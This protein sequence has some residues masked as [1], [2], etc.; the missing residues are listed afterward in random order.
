MTSLSVSNNITDF[1]Q[2]EIDDAD[3]VGQRN[4]ARSTR[5]FQRANYALPISPLNPRWQQK[6]DKTFHFIISAQADLWTESGLE[7]I[8]SIARE[9]LATKTE[10]NKK[11]KSQRK[12]C[13]NSRLEHF[14]DGRKCSSKNNTANNCIYAKTPLL[15]WRY[16]FMTRAWYHSDGKSFAGSWQIR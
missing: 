2:L 9:K 6:A 3:A 12:L 10:Q 5:N 15:V 11:W 7:K 13:R 8:A 14:W 4:V 16:E 1:K